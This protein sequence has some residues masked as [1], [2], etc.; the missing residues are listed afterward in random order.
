[1]LSK[2]LKEIKK[3]R[4]ILGSSSLSRKDCLELLGVDFSIKKSD[5]EENLSKSDFSS[6]EDY[7]LETCRNKMLDLTEKMKD[8]ENYDIL[9]TADT[10]IKNIDNQILEKPKDL[11]EHIE[12]LKSYSNS[13]ITVITAMILRIKT[14]NGY[15]VDSCVETAK[16]FYD[17]IDE[18]FI[19]IF[20]DQEPES[21]N[22][23][24][25]FKIEGML[26]LVINR[27]EGDPEIVRG[28]STRSLFYRWAKVLQEN[29]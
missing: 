15:V 20:I 29:E 24:G 19:K 1:M 16:M 7:C 10:I 8:E 11:Q 3:K 2:L 6:A 14:K 5:F 21:R 23:S 22:C 9:I 25:G 27:I 4:I 12:F 26:K 18:E 17:F 28:L 13:E